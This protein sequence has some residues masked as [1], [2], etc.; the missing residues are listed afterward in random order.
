M[1]FPGRQS[2][3]PLLAIFGALLITA[4][5]ALDVSAEAQMSATTYKK[6][7]KARTLLDEKQGETALELLMDYRRRVKSRPVDNAIVHQFMANILVQLDRIDEAVEIVGSAYQQPRMPERLGILYGKLLVIQENYTEAEK[8]L[9]DRINLEEDVPAEAVYTLAFTRFHLENFALAETSLLEAIGM[10]KVVPRSWHELLLAL[11]YQQQ[12]FESAEQL[13]K[14]MVEKRPLDGESWRRLARIYLEQSKYSEALGALMSAHHKGLLSHHDIKQIA[15][16]HGHLDMPENAARMLA[17]WLQQ[18]NQ[19]SSREEKGPGKV[20]ADEKQQQQSSVSD[21]KKPATAAELA[22][23]KRRQELD[24]LRQLG[25]Y[26]LIAREY[27]TAKQIFAQAERKDSKGTT[28]LMLG[29][30]YFDD[31]QW[32]KA[33]QFFTIA[34]EKGSLKD[35][36]NTRLLLG[37]CYFRQQ[38]YAQANEQFDLLRRS[39]KQAAAAAYWKNKINKISARKAASG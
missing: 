38:Q 23:Q 3:K 26:W 36:D 20:A 6:L 18:E 22:V 5:M 14:M 32:E 28:A 12:K 24:L 16:L 9:S 4:L 25:S 7:E 29:N 13:A 39:K 10:V 17:L 34:L 35:P 30:I 1:Q 37:L 31:E 21:G 8:V 27:E 11:Y 15:S 33:H 19:L 2:S